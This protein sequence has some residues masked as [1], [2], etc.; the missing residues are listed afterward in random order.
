MGADYRQRREQC[1]LCGDYSDERDM[2]PCPRCRN[3]ICAT[4]S[5]GYGACP[6]CDND[7][8]HER[9][10]DAGPIGARPFRGIPMNSENTRGREKCERIVIKAAGEHHSGLDHG[11]GH[12][13]EVCIR[14]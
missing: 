11:C 1:D 5:P 10:S 12:A 7:A 13:G 14:V 4:C 3:R 2:H 8:R 9:N 6:M